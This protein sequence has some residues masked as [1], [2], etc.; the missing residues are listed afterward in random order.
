MH[1]RQDALVDGRSE[2]PLGQALPPG[3]QLVP[4][5]RRDPEVI[6]GQWKAVPVRIAME[7]FLE[8]DRVVAGVAGTPIPSLLGQRPILPTAVLRAPG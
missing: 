7:H 6:P 5:R 2:R 3:S 8:H 1:T 4:R